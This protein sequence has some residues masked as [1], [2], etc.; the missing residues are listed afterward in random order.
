[1]AAGAAQEGPK[2]KVIHHE[3]GAVV[4]RLDERPRVPDLRGLDA[5]VCVCV[6]V[7]VCVCVCVFPRFD[8]S[9]LVD[10]VDPHSYLTV[11]GPMCRPSWNHTLCCPGFGSSQSPV[12]GWIPLLYMVR[13]TMDS[14]FLGKRGGPSYCCS[15][16]ITDIYLLASV[17][18]AEPSG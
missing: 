8:S 12:S 3:H 6:G 14:G 11:G 17:S 4:H 10:G 7:G 18:C 1:M 13:S 2:G 16:T 9:T 5:C 15:T